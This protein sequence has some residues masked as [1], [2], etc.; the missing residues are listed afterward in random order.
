[1]VESSDLSGTGWSDLLTRIQNAGKFVDLDLSACTMTGTEFDPGTADTG[2]RLIVSLILP[3]AAESIGGVS[4][5]YNNTFEHFT[6]LK[7]VTGAHIKTIGRYAFRKCTALAMADFPE[8]VTIGEGTFM[9]C[10]VLTAADFPEVVTIGEG[11]FAYGTRLTTLNFPQAA[12]IGS[13]AFR[14]CDRLTSVQLPAS[15]DTIGS[16][17]PFWGCINLTNIIVAPGNSHFKAEGGKLLSINGTALIAYPT[18]T[19]N[20]TLDTTITAIGGGAFMTCALTSIS[21]SGALSIGNDAFSGCKALKTVNLP[22]ATF[23]G[24]Y[25]FSYCYALKSI[26]LPAAVTIGPSVFSGCMALEEVNLPQAAS[27]GNQAFAY[28]GTARDL[29]VILGN[30]PPTLETSMFHNVPYFGETGTKTVIV[31]VPSGAATGYAASL[32]AV[33]SGAENTAN[34]P[35]WGEGFRGKGW[36]GGGMYPASPDTVNTNINLTIQQLP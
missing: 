11:A 29:T 25:A 28:T 2:E 7:S 24:A 31:K 21:G 9:E 14:Y 23:I 22:Q 12:S 26:G 18:A 19:G 16:E 30:T 8:A 4:D 10:T 15:L 36:I 34:G 3:N 5:G 35:Q 32:P 27:I 20:I 13:G 6:Y 17:N 33:Y 1:M